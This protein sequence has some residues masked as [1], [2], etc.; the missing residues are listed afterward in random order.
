[1][2]PPCPHFLGSQMESCTPLSHPPPPLPHFPH[3]SSSSAELVPLGA[4]SLFGAE[5][6][7]TTV[8]ALAGKNCG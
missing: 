4:R 1:M 7:L 6:G 2:T 8:A 5:V 3:V